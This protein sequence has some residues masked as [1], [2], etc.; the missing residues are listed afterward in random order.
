MTTVDLFKHL[1]H[2]TR[3]VATVIVQELEKEVVVRKLEGSGAETDKWEWSHM[4]VH[5]LT[6]EPELYVCM[7]SAFTLVVRCTLHKQLCYIKYSLS[8][9]YVTHAMIVIACYICML[10]ITR[11]IIIQLK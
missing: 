11:S 6:F 8:S 7:L 2:S 5:S 10:R 9:C 1:G 3:T 4:S